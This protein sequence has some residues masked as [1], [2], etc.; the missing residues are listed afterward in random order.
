MR[1]TKWILRIVVKHEHRT[2]TLGISLFRCDIGNMDD[3]LRRRDGA[4]PDAGLS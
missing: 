4:S 3:L 2:F 1:M